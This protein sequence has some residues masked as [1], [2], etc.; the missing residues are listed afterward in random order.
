M[1]HISSSLSETIATGSGSSIGKKSDT[2]S[3]SFCELKIGPGSSRLFLMKTVSS[4][5][6]AATVSLG[7][8]ASPAAIETNS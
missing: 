8:V 4:S 1:S 5:E 3:T 6:A 7:K 2:D